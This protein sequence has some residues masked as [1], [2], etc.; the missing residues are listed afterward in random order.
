V[1]G[2]GQLLQPRAVDTPKM[3]LP[4]RRLLQSAVHILFR[5]ILI[6][7]R[8]WQAQCNHAAAAAPRPSP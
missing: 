2:L 7:W 8:V 6:I 4:C 1:H 5:Y 3:T